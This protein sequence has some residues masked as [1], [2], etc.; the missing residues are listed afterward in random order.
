MQVVIKKF[1][2]MYNG[3][4]YI[5]GQV[6]DLPDDV[7]ASLVANAPKEFSL[8]QAEQQPVKKGRAG[9]KAA[10]DAEELPAIDAGALVK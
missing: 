4:R 5:A 2:L 10:Q 9:K 1:S 6:A 7:A 3:E 8:V